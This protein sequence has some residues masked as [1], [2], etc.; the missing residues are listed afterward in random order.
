[1]PLLIDSESIFLFM[2]VPFILYL[3]KEVSQE[4]K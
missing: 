2:S 1:M 3:M 4:Q